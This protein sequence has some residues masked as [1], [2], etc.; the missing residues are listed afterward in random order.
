MSAK[1]VIVT[2]FENQNYTSLT[3]AYRTPVLPTLCH[4]VYF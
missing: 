2:L 1:K 4:L 3:S